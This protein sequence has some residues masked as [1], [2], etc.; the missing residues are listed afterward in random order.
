MALENQ[1]YCALRR[2]DFAGAASAASEALAKIEAGKQFDLIRGKA[3]I[4][5]GKALLTAGD[6]A[7]A[8]SDMD[9]T[10]EL[11][12]T[13]LNFHFAAGTRSTIAAWLELQ[14]EFEARK[15]NTRDAMDSISKAVEERRDVSKLPHVQG[16]YTMVALARALAKF[17]EISLQT[18]D[19]A[20]A[21]K[22]NLE[23]K[24]IWESLGLAS[25]AT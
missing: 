3:L 18:G 11:L 4:L 12:G 1:G 20:S 16:P 7:G 6:L 8:Q 17:G 24:S 21:E 23:A 5:R 9:A 19:P 14:A 2:N 25:P 22:A 10:L 13:P 15:G